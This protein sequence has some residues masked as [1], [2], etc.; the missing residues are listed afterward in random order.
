MDVKEKQHPISQIK[1]IRPDLDDDQEDNNIAIK[2][3]KNEEYFNSK[4][5][6]TMRTTSSSTTAT[7]STESIEVAGASSNLSARAL[8]LAHEIVTRN[9]SSSSI[10]QSRPF[11]PIQPIFI[12]LIFLVIFLVSIGTIIY[13]SYTSHSGG[14]ESPSESRIEQRSSGEYTA[15]KV[16]IDD[17][18]DSDSRSSSNQHSSSK[19]AQSTTSASATS[20]D[21]SLTASSDNV[22]NVYNSLVKKI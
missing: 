14:D 11:N 2:S 7:T 12:G 8:E 4:F 10:I 5:F 6:T 20:C 18:E 1:P 9:L 3:H 16:T 21:H 19:A 22:D 15:V 13:L 17:D